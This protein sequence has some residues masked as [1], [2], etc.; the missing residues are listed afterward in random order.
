MIVLANITNFFK[1]SRIKDGLQY[2]KGRFSD[3]CNFSVENGQIFDDCIL[4]VTCCFSTRDKRK[5]C[6]NPKFTTPEQ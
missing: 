1:M 4:Y 6:R 5:V 2:S 3:K